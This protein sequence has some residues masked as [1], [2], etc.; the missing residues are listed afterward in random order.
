MSSLFSWLNRY[1]PPVS[2]DGTSV[3]H[4]Q[5]MAD[6]PSMEEYLAAQRR[7]RKIGIRD[8]LRVMT[9][10]QMKL[11]STPPD[12]PAPEVGPQQGPSMEDF[13]KYQ[14]QN[15]A[16]DRIREAQA[17]EGRMMDTRDGAITDRAAMSMEE[18]RRAAAKQSLSANRM[19]PEARVHYPIHDFFFPPDGPQPE[20]AAAPTPAPDPSIQ[21]DRATRARPSDLGPGVRPTKSKTVAVPDQQPS[22]PISE[23]QR[24]KAMIDQIY[25]AM[26]QF[27]Q[28]EGALDKEMELEKERAKYMA[29]LA[30]F[31]GITQGAGGSW[32]SVGRGMAAAGNAYSDGFSRYQKALTGRMERM[33]ERQKMQYDN[34][35]SRTDA[36]LKLYQTDSE[37]VLE[38]QKQDREDRKERR[39]EILKQIEIM[40]PQG[41]FVDPEEWEK[42]R[43]TA[44]KSLEL[45]VPIYSIDD[46]SDK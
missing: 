9:P 6:Q 23:I 7:A 2:P 37:R 39:A 44:L 40:K 22:D 34:D 42:Y 24:K 19:P 5:Q 18:Q 15:N 30:F 13:W 10:D 11:F 35:V 46:V 8:Q 41:D 20:E 1:F 4:P 28:G 25:P 29:Q 43:K 17:S 33:N 16:M 12:V 21:E 26:P 32:E 31:S 38:K 36:A 3:M 14:N 45:G 27:D